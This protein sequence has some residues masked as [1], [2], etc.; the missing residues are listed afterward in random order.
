MD[1]PTTPPHQNS[2]ETIERGNALLAEAKR[3]LELGLSLGRHS[4]E[5]RELADQAYV[6]HRR[7]RQEAE[8]LL[9]GSRY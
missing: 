5:L 4:E 9:L 8:T 3:S 6:A 7:Y 1:K 2:P